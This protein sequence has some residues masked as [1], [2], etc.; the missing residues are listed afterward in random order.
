LLIITKGE[1]DRVADISQLA[2]FGAAEL[3]AARHLAVMDI[4][5]GNDPLC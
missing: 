2:R 5:A 3:N 1:L 4:Q